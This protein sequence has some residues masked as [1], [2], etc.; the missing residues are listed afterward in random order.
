MSVEY[1]CFDIVLLDELRCLFFSVKN[2]NE[3]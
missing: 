3:F 2:E 1:A